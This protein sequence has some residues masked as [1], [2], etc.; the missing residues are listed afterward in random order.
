MTTVVAQLSPAPAATVPSTSTTTSGYPATARSAIA[1]AEPNK[2][3][4]DASKT[5]AA[6]SSAEGETVAKVEPLASTTAAAVVPP[7]PGSEGAGD[8]PGGE[9]SNEPKE[10][11]AAAAEV[12][13]VCACARLVC[14]DSSGRFFCRFTAKYTNRR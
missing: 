8:A 3:I 11:N 2:E 7:E 4:D 14:G 13:F 10:G 5:A 1:A 9:S 6:V 12:C